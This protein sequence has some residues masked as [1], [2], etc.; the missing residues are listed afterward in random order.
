MEADSPVPES[1]A[2]L[3]PTKTVLSHDHATPTALSVI[4]GPPHPV[5]ASPLHRSLSAADINHITLDLGCYTSRFGAELYQSTDLPTPTISL[6]L[7]IA[8]RNDAAMHVVKEVSIIAEAIAYLKP[9]VVIVY[10]DLPGSVAAATAARAVGVQ[11]V[12]AEAGR[13]NRDAGD[14]E[15]YNRLSISSKADLHLAPSIIAQRNLVSE[16]ITLDRA[17]I[18]GN[19]AIETL[20]AIISRVP[21]PGHGREQP[22]I[23][24]AF[25][26]HE[27]LMSPDKM[28][29]VAEVIKNLPTSLPKIVLDYGSP[30][31]RSRVGARHDFSILPR[32]SL[33]SYAALLL[34]TAVALTDSSGLQ[35]D[36]AALG[37]PCVTMRDATHCAESVELGTNVVV[38]YDSQQALA[39]VSQALESTP[40]SP[41]LTHWGRE[42]GAKAAYAICELLGN[43]I[44][45][46]P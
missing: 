42:A 32:V 30:R 19:L 17:V 15:E 27:L 31:L 14:G 4:A 36:T 29:E 39:Q 5:K 45:A 3:T 44:D 22:V 9:D 37:I 26:R 2:I 6:S 46:R 10:G 34:H 25:H 41:T 40:G 23:L 13:R 16:G 1:P 7:S 24:V 38:G 8:N 43:R 35:D 33:R 28:N 21:K 11:I 18:I 12:H 20:L